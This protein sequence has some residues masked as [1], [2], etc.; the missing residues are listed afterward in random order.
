MMWYFIM[1]FGHSSVG[2]S[3]GTLIFV[4]TTRAGSRQME[5]SVNF[6]NSYPIRSFCCGIVCL[7]R[8]VYRIAHK[9]KRK[10]SFVNVLICNIQVHVLQ[11]GCNAM[12]MYPTS[13]ERPT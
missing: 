12:G 10:R 1:R 3:W 2:D 13:W 5:V 9:L 4:A 6:R 8:F 7:V 11:S